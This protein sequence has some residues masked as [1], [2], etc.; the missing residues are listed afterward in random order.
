ML[1]APPFLSFPLEP[2]VQLLCQVKQGWEGSQQK[3][4][5]TP[6]QNMVHA[7]SL[8]RDRESGANRPGALLTHR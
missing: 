2:L 6:Y 4:G 3:R 7:L 1:S 5:V 8:V